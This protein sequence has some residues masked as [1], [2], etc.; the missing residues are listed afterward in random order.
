MYDVSVDWWIENPA[1]KAIGIFFP[2]GWFDASLVLVTK[3][4]S[5]KLNIA[6]ILFS[7]SRPFSASLWFL[8]ITMWVFAGVV[9]WIVEDGDLDGDGGDR[10]RA[11]FRYSRNWQV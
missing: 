3:K 9:Y 6:D 5:T 8:V 1:R 2:M 10:N 7:W 11:E 4:R